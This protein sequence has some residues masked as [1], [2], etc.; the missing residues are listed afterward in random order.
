MDYIVANITNQREIRVSNHEME[1]RVLY[2]GRKMAIPDEILPYIIFHTHDKFSG[3]YY[4]LDY[5]KWKTIHNL[6]PITPRTGDCWFRDTDN[7]RALLTSYDT[8]LQTLTEIVGE[9][10]IIYIIET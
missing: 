4:F 10:K 1:G 2:Q 5:K 7:K 9:F 3:S 6:S 8:L